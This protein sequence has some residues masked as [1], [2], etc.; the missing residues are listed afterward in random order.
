MVLATVNVA[1]RVPFDDFG[2]L[3]E[4]SFAS[5]VI[6]GSAIQRFVKVK[7]EQELP[8]SPSLDVGLQVLIILLVA[9]VLVLSLLIVNDHRQ[10]SS[11]AVSTLGG[12]QLALF[13]C[14]LSCL[15]TYVRVEK[16]DRLKRGEFRL[17][18]RH[19]TARERLAV[20]LEYLCNHLDTLRRN[21]AS[22][23]SL[24]SEPQEGSTE[25]SVLNAWRVRNAAANLKLMAELAANDAVAVLGAAS[26]APDPQTSQE[27]G[28]PD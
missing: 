17:A 27:P 1:L 10:L 23:R 5:I 20:A 28:T 4:W 22:E 9:A 6:Y 16:Q 24:L 12:M 11:A 14:S 3:K 18:Y 15:F 25:P 26:A 7:F 8:R 13:A 2:L 21:I 19:D